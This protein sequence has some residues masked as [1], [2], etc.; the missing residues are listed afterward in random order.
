MR[1]SVRY[2]RSTWTVFCGIAAV[3]LIVLWV[4]SYWWSEEII[5]ETLSCYPFAES[6]R[7]QLAFGMPQR[8]T[9]AHA[10]NAD[11]MLRTYPVNTSPKP[12]LERAFQP[13]A[14]PNYPG[15][16]LPHWSVVILIVASA[17]VPWIS[18]RFSYVGACQ[19]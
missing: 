8:N 11:W 15:L 13:F 6:T 7:G 16:I 12:F 4:R 9:S 17:V 18:F 14:V 10:Q 1:K 2:L 5:G 19:V 3:L